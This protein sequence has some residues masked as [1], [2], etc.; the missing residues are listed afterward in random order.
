MGDDFTA[1]CVAG[2]AERVSGINKIIKCFVL[3]VVLAIQIPLIAFGHAAA[4][5][6]DSIN[7]A[8]IDK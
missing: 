2:L 1:P 5:M 7:K 3:F 8:A 6:G 4:N